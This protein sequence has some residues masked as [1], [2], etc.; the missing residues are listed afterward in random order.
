MD[1]FDGDATEGEVFGEL[2]VVNGD[3]GSVGAEPF[4]ED[5]HGSLMDRAFSP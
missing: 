2:G 3:A 5:V 1:A 4:G